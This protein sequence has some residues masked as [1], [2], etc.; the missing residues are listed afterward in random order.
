[1][2][3]KNVKVTMS[4]VGLTAGDTPRQV[5]YMPLAKISYVEKEHRSKTVLLD[6]TLVPDKK[7]FKGWIIG[8]SYFA[9]ITKDSC[10]IYDENGNRTG[11]V[12]I[13][14]FGK[15]IQA[16]E[17]NFICLKGKTVSWI[18]KNGECVGSRELTVEE[19]KSV[20]EE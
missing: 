13:E 8:V 20:K 17:D 16:N 2:K 14:E 18:A 1:M 10:Q 11:T 6:E 12:S 7:Y 19:L 4:Y 3:I 15:P 9:G 5:S